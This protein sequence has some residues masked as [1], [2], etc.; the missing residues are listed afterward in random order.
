MKTLVATYVTVVA[1][2]L[3]GVATEAHAA[4]KAKA[5]P[6]AKAK[7][8]ASREKASDD[9][10][11]DQE[12]GKKGKKGKQ[13]LKFAGFKLKGDLKKPDLSYIYKR[14]GVKD[15]QIVNIPVDF[16]DEIRQGENQF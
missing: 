8:A 2:A 15:E 7:T 9:G 12:K 5:K 11:D 1:L 10:D 14:R 3:A 13:D 4:K 6:K 16:N